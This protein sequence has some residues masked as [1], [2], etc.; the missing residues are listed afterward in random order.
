MYAIYL[1][2]ISLFYYSTQCKLLWI[3]SATVKCNLGYKVFPL[4]KKKIFEKINS[5]DETRTPLSTAA[6]SSNISGFSSFFF[7][8][9]SLV[10]QT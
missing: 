10:A 9:A 8:S 5:L 6:E 3:K 1:A 2:V 7:S 4:N